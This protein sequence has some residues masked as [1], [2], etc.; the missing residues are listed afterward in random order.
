MIKFIKRVLFGKADSTFIEFIRS[1]ITG[2]IAFIVD[3][4][5]LTLFKEVFGM[6]ALV[7][8]I[9]SFIL[10]TTVNYIISIKWTYANTNVNN[11]SVRFVVFFLISVGG[12]LINSY[13]VNLFDTT[14]AAK[15]VFGSLIPTRFYYM[16]G[17]VVATVVGYIW[18]FSARKLLLFRKQK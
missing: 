12:L 3:F 11:G 2:G 9:I 16:I 1:V 6:T 8:S 10:G 18:N 17:K 13:I 5:F 4:G 14:L 15:Q 7:A